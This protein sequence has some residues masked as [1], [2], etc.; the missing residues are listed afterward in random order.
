MTFHHYMSRSAGAAVLVSQ[1]LFASG[2]AAEEDE[3]EAKPVTSASVSTLSVDSGQTVYSGSDVTSGAPPMTIRTSTGNWEFGYHGYLRAPFRMSFD[4]EPLMKYKRDADGN[5]ME[6]DDGL[7]IRE[8][9]GEEWHINTP[10]AM[11]NNSYPTW[12]Y[13]KNMPNPWAE[14][15]LSYGNSVAIGNVSL[16]AWSLTDGSWRNTNT[17]LGID[18]AWVTMNWAN[19]F[20][21]RGG[22]KLEV[23]VF[24]NR[25]GASGRWDPGVYDTY[26]FGRTHVAG[27]TLTANIDLADKMTLYLE[28]GFGAK[29]DVLEGNPQ[30]TLSVSP[31]AGDNTMSWLPYAGQ[32]NYPAFVNH[33]HAGLLIHT[34]A[35][36]DEFWVNAHF[37]HA[38]TASAS[39]SDNAAII[40]EDWEKDGKDGKY[41]IAGGEV[42]FNGAIFGDLYLGFSTIRTENIATMPDAIEVI[43]TLGGWSYLKNY[44]G[45]VQLKAPDDP[46]LPNKKE[47][48]NPGNGRVNT[49]LWQYAFS[50]AR[51]VWYMHSERF[52]GQGPDLQI[53]FF[54][55][56]T[57][58]KPDKDLIPYL[59]RYAEKKLKFGGEVF[60]T[61]HKYFGFGMRVDRV[62]PDMDYDPANTE[63]NHGNL[64]S[65]APFTELTPEIRIKTAFIT[66][67][68]LNIKYS[69]MFWK[70]DRD[71]VRAENPHESVTADR[72]ALMVE[73]NMWW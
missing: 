69:R 40:E 36:W 45:D 31:D 50:V 18:R 30:G 7:P 11:P 15:I 4:T 13:T 35:I 5:V 68:E 73:V 39:E 24:G 38:F 53:R 51:L 14:M 63:W 34:K 20:R 72:N 9:T 64:T 16:A 47:Q 8:K 28:H 23:G 46:N 58:V 65:Y 17:Q 57:T 29:T 42:K 71:E 21:K 49:L 55:M 59:K 70:G 66:H 32:G 25:Y 61:P 19:A 60:Y 56:F 1:L 44:Y 62:I 22:L 54:G 48:L 37:M 43:H 6:G 27:E 2:A 52:W 67:E 12:A 3:E 26:L 41:L 10:Q 33:A